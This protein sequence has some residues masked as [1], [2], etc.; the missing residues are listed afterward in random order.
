M[1][2]TILESTKVKYNGR[3]LTAF[4]TYNDIDEKTA[5]ELIAS[6]DAKQAD[7]K[8]AAVSVTTENH[9]PKTE[10]FDPERNGGYKAR[11]KL[12]P[13]Q[14]K[15]LEE[16]GKATNAKG[17]EVPADDL[18]ITD[19]DET[20]KSSV[21]DPKVDAE[22]VE[23]KDENGKVLTPEEITAKEQAN[24]VS[25]SEATPTVEEAQRTGEEVPAV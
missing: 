22:E 12:T 14:E 7:D 13:K 9:V 21:E 1:N 16:K 11:A 2:V 19:K 10:K 6:G 15:D 25:G 23:V 18:P 24:A 5:S 8:I 4:Q 20:V 3:F 17:E